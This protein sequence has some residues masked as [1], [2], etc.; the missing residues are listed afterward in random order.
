MNNGEKSKGILDFLYEY[1]KKKSIRFHMPGHKGKNMEKVSSMIPSF[2][3]TEI[4]GS[5]NLHYPKTVIKESEIRAAELYGVKEILFMVNGSTSSIYSAI[6]G[7]L[8]PGQKLLLQRDSHKAAY[9]AAVL[10]GIETEYIYPEYDHKLQLNLGIRAEDVENILK[11]DSSIKAVFMTYPSYYGICSDLEAI[12]KVVKAYDRILIVDEAH[13]SHLKFNESLPESAVDLGADIVVHSTH[14]T[15]TGFTQTSM[16]HICTSRVNTEKIR[17]M[18]A[19]YQSTSPSYILMASLDY[20]VELMSG[21]G[22]AMLKDVLDNLD[23]EIYRKTVIDSNSPDE[24]GKI[25]YSGNSDTEEFRNSNSALKILN[26]E[27]VESRGYG[28]DRTKIVF[29][30][31]GY[32]GKE[33][34]NSL[35]DDYNIELEMS[36]QK[37]GLGMSTIFDS[38]EDIRALYSAL[39][40]MAEKPSKEN[41]IKEYGI[42]DKLTDNSQIKHRSINSTG[43]LNLREAFYSDKEDVDLADA[44]GRLAGEMITPY[45]PGIPIFVPGEMIDE[46][47]VD[48]IKYLIGLGITVQGVADGKVKVI[49]SV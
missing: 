3:I 37:Y 45:P 46:D 21:T 19:I 28:F 49:K 31:V 22:K 38:K 14:K 26:R 29:T 39:S 5:D 17:A 32:T 33:L 8:S 11:K 6:T 40:E 27:L 16:L 23:R 41:Q 42:L 34:E 43:T 4:K 36:D 30:I 44:S 48:Y 18:A 15:L 9:N 2:D 47:S 35:R 7:V 25:K 13:G 12:A 20:T 10:G 1:D 24:S